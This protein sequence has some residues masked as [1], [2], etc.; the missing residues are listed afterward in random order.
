MN[1]VSVYRFS[2]NDHLMATCRFTDQFPTTIPNVSAQNRETVFRRPDR[3][4]LAVPDRV[5]A[6]LVSFHPLT[7]R[8]KMPPAQAA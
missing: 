5:A 6:A 4:I 8:C 3:V 1:M 7:L 2:V